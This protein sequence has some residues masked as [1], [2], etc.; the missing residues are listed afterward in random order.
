[1]T[2]ASDVCY[3]VSALLESPIPAALDAAREAS[4][5]WVMLEAHVL[6]DRLV[7]R[8]SD[9]GSGVP[10]RHQDDIF[11]PWFTTKPPGSGTG[12]GLAIARRL[13]QRNDGDV[14]YVPDQA[15]TT[16]EL[17]LPSAVGVEETVR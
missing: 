9:S 2:S 6:G 1:M 15:N 17:E 3:A 7:L 4:D 10:A 8:C 5:A 14:R 13:L 12:L 11:E 16:F